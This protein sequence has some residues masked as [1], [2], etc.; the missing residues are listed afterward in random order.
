MRRAFLA[1]GMAIALPQTAQACAQ[2]SADI[3]MCDRNT[4]WEM[5]EWDPASDGAARFLDDLVLTFSDEWPGYEIGDDLSTL[6]ERFATYEEWIKAEGEAPLQKLQFDRLTVANATAVRSLERDEIE[7]KAF[8]S[9]VML[10]QVGMGRIMLYL[11]AP[12]TTALSDL[13]SISRNVLA[14]LHDNC[15]DPV[16]CAE[17]YQRPGAAEERG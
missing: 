10:A 2:L 6:E 15:A 7:G 17:D 11:D 16:S 8:M 5:A 12:D 14:L 4:A 13:D 3:W 1:F 9:A